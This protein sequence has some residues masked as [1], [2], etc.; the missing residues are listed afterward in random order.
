MPKGIYEHKKSDKLCAVEN[1]NKEYSA[2]GFCKIHYGRYIRHGDPNICLRSHF[3]DKC[4]SVDICNGKYYS[5]GYCQKH[6]LKYN[7]PDYRELNCTIEGCFKKCTKSS[8]YYCSMHSNRK[9]KGLPM[10]APAMR[11]ANGVGSIN[12]QGYRVFEIDGKRYLEHREVMEKFLGRQLS[13][14]ENVHHKNG[15]RL[16]NRIENLELWNTHQPKGQRVEDKIVWAKE[17]LE[18][19]EGYNDPKK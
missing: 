12:V 2:K 5:K 18:L 4:C 15:N 17:I 8:K 19:Y 7:R 16:D 1:C 9:T 11:G 14:N 10:N 3:N 13:S 6:Y